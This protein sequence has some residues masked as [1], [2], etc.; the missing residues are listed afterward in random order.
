MLAIVNTLA[1]GTIQEKLTS[2][3][4]AWRKF[5]EKILEPLLQ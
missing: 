3:N 1:A 4:G 5:S 2:F